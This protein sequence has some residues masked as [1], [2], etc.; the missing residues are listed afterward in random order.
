MSL[1]RCVFDLITSISATSWMDR[2]ILEHQ[3]RK[4]LRSWKDC[5]SIPLDM[6]F[7]HTLSMLCGGGKIPVG[8]NYLLAQAPGR[9]VL[10]NFEGFVATYQEPL[11]YDPGEIK[12]QEQLIERRSEPGQE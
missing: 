7:P 4:G 11:D 9:V 5:A 2:V 10:R 1:S 8:P 3:Y 6:Q 12:D